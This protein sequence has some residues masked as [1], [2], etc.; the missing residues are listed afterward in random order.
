M[1]DSTFTPEIKE[2]D[3]GEPCRI[4]LNLHSKLAGLSGKDILISLPDGTGIEEAKEL[5]KALSKFN[6]RISIL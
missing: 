4:L 2:R 3:S 6:L 1:S 5:E